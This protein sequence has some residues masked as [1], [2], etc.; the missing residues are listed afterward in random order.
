V[1]D[2]QRE[3][4]AVPSSFKENYFRD[5][6]EAWKKLWNQCTG[7]VTELS[8]LA[9]VFFSWIGWSGEDATTVTHNGAVDWSTV[10]FY[11]ESVLQKRLQFH[12]RPA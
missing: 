3:S 2:I 9:T 1:F 4:Q 12:D 6:F 5:A 8:Y 7:C 11:C 10:C